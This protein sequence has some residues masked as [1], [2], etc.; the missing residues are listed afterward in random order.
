M[1]SMGE[2]CV[3]LSGL[4]QPIN[5]FLKSLIDFCSSETFPKHMILKM[6][7]FFRQIEET[8]PHLAKAK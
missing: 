7:L 1:H 6:S 5:S 8:K 3:T 2:G 4:W